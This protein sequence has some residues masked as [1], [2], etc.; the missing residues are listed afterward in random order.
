MASVSQGITVEMCRHFVTQR[1]EF[2]VIL[3][4]SLLEGT[5]VLSSEGQCG[6]SMRTLVWGGTRARLDS[7]TNNRLIALFYKLGVLT[8]SVLNQCFRCK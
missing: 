3:T 7:A 5:V 1:A 8:M 2:V 6:R 4:G